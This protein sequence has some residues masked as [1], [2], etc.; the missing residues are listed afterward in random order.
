MEASIESGMRQEGR[1]WEAKAAVCVWS[2]S[3]HPSH[4]RFLTVKLHIDR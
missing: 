2:I 3:G 4:M 1:L